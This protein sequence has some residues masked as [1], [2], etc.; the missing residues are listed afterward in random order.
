MKR[1][2]SRLLLCVMLVLLASS[3][4]A[5]PVVGDVLFTRDAKVKDSDEFPPATFSHWLHRVK[6]KCFV[7]HSKEIG[8]EMKAGSAPITMDAIGDGKYCGACHKGRPAFAVG[9]E[10]CSRCHRK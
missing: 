8:F 10:T 2:V 7:C 3:A 4:M 1:S 5:A 6:F 9:F